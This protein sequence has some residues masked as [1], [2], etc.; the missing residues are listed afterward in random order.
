MPAS[1]AAG[2]FLIASPHLDNL[3]TDD[4]GDPQFNRTVV[5]LLQH[6]PDEGTIGVVINRPLGKEI[7]LY[8]NEALKRLTDGLQNIQEIS[9]SALGSVKGKKLGLKRVFTLSSNISVAKWFNTP[10]KSAKLTFVSIYSPS[11]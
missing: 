3:G 4:R 6:Q 7:T 5:L 8:T 10:F 9:I 1:L 11:T 2:T